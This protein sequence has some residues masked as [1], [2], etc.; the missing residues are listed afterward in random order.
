MANLSNI[1]NI[2]RT[3]S[4]G[5]GINCDAEFS[6]DI[7]KASANAILSLNS[8]G[9]SGAEYVLSSTTAGEFVINKRYVGDRLTISSGGDATFSGNI[10][11]GVVN[12]FVQSTNVLDG[13]GASGARIRSAVSAAGTPTFSNSDDTDTGMFF[14]SANSVA[15]S[16]GGTQ[17]LSIDSSQ[18]ATF[19]S[20]VVINHS[21][22]DSLLLTKSTT[23]PSLR[24]EGDTDKD[25][26]LTI[27]GETFTVTQNDGATDILTL[28]HDTKNATFSSSIGLGG[29]TI[30]NNYMIEITASGGNIIRSTRGTSVFAAY[31]SNNSDVYLGT[32]S[33]NTFKIITN[34][35][36]AITIGSNKG[37]QL[38]GYGSGSFTGTTAYTLAVD[39]SGNIIETTD[40]GGTVKGTGTATRVAFWSASDTISSNADLYWDNSNDRLGIG[41]T[42]PNAKLDVNRGASGNIASFKSNATSSGD[43]AGIT[44]HTQSISGNDWYGSELRSISTA[45]TPSSLNPR[46]GFFTQDNNTYLPADRTEKMSILGNGNV[47]IGTTTPDEKLDITGGYLKFNGGDYGLKGS[48]SL[49]YNPVSDHYF[50]SNGT[51]KM[52]IASTG[53]V[54][55]MGATPSVNNSL[56]LG[57]NSTAGSAEISAKSTAGNTHF[58]FYTS[59]AGTTSEKLRIKHNG[60][61]GINYT[62]APYKLSVKEDGTATTNI[63]IYALANGAGTNNYAIYAD[64]NS[65]TSTNFGIYSNSGTNAFLGSVGIGTDSPGTKLDI[66]GMA[67][68]VLRIKSDA[69]GDP[70]LRFDAAAANRSARIKFYDNGSAVGGFI[71]YLHNGD[72]MNFGA[73]SS[74][75]V[76]MTVGDGAV[77]IGTTSPSYPLEVAGIEVSAKFVGS[78]TGHV[79]GAILL[80]GGTDSTP[81]ARGQGVYRFNEGNDETWYTGTAYANTNRYIWARKTSTTSFD[82]GAAQLTYAMMAL[83]NDGKLGIGTTSPATKLQVANAGEVIVRSSMTAADGYRGGFEADNQH[84]GGTIWSMFSTND[85]DGYFGGG[86]F[87]IANESM[88]G[89]DVNTPAKFVIDGGGSVLIGD[90]IPS[91]TPEADYRSLEIGRQGNTITGAPWKSNLYLTCNATITAGSSAFTYR[92]ASEAPARMDLEDGYIRFLNAAAG[93]AGNTISWSENMR[94]ASDGKVGIGTTN[95]SGDLDVAGPYAFFGTEQA[96]NGITYLTLRNYDSTLVDAGDVQNMIRMTGRYWSGAT[97]QLVETR[98]TSI[99]QISN[100]NGGSALGFMTQTGGSSPVEHMRIDKDGNVGIGDTTPSYKL[101]VNGTIRATGDVIA[102]SDRRVKENIK[103]IDNSLEKVDQLRGVEFNKI[104]ENKKSIG[105]IAQEIEKVL[106][107]VV[108]TDDNGMKSVAY[109]NMAGLFIEAIKELKAE[110]EELKKHSCDC[111]K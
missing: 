103:T 72:K 54:Y 100:G 91:G 26:V 40:G 36:T 110:I 42:S 62:T 29:A 53:I 104:G 65:G 37:V 92:Y 96:N 76:T 15:L 81:E 99:K 19:A 24:F 59:N 21:S 88:G 70:E 6:L 97:S 11:F 8:S 75:G 82:S 94:I 49:T 69:G 2:L 4:A 39:S 1:N 87:V 13:T 44:L 80:S 38:N 58:E 89:V 5:V 22:G 61:V 48:A 18:N 31:Q 93:T 51:E 12:P 32:T 85:S 52:R 14:P 33:N 50:Q 106:P 43:Y 45:G 98:I 84:T 67:D 47:G 60:N 71:D 57:Y 23:E 109:G 107:E 68:P 55:I 64:A 95:P 79:Q 86:K 9:G 7:E 20:K 63:G 77:G 101:D 83:T 105:V 35:A 46:L 30:A 66:G 3:S 73:G 102:Y 111:K 78:Q 90:G 108:I 10:T 16:T 28:D 56:Q 34:D 74:T 41:T 17:A 27:S 25:F